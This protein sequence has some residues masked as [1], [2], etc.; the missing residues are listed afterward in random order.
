M[1]LY[2]VSFYWSCACSIYPVFIAHLI[3]VSALDLEIDLVPKCPAVRKEDHLCTEEGHQPSGWHVE[4]TGNA[5]QIMSVA[6]N[7]GQLTK[8][9]EYGA[10]PCIATNTALNLSLGLTSQN[11][12][13]RHLSSLIRMYLNWALQGSVPAIT[14]WLKPSKHSIAKKK[15]KYQGYA[16]WNPH[17]SR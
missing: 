5:S 13:R 17:W 4:E 2:T 12:S 11:G 15:V 7:G 1:V 8:T 14:T 9:H 3:I 6:K 16:R 10:L